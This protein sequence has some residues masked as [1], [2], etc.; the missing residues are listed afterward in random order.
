MS[1]AF[2]VSPFD[3]AVVVSV[4]GFGDFASAA[5]GVGHGTRIEVEDKVFFPHSLG[6]FY[7]AIT[8]FIGFPH[9]GDEYKMMGLAPYGEPAFMEQ[10]RRIVQ[11][12][13]DGGFRLDLD[14]FRHH[15]EKIDYQWENGSPG[16]GVLVRARDGGPAGARA[17]SRTSRSPSAT[18]TSP[19]RRRRCTRKPSSTC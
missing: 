13:P 16:V 17:R 11:L 9:Y 18:G 4:D 19:V 6:V 8:Q 5:W 12:Q 3:E 7:Q 1:S 10:M 15:R 2:H 14:L